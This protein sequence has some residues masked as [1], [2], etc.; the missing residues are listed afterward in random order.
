VGREQA[1][2]FVV[3]EAVT[4][5]GLV[6]QAQDGARQVAQLRFQ[7]GVAGE[8][9]GLRR[10]VAQP[11]ALQVDDGRVRLIVAVKPTTEACAVFGHGDL[12]PVAI[13]ELA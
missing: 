8:P 10:F 2:V 12:G 3:I 4:G 5:C 7:V 9:A 6:A 13:A 1:V 11:G